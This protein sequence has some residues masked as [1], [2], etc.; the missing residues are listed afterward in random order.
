MNQLWIAFKNVQRNRRRSLVT[1][2]IAAAGTAAVMIGGGFALYT[3]DALR[4]Q[5]ARDSG[6]VIVAAHGFFDHDEE[7]PMQYGLENYPE[8]RRRLLLDARVRAVLPKVQLSGLISNGDKS[9]VMIG[10]GVDPAGEFHVRGPFLKVLEGD[11]LASRP[12]AGGTPEVLLGGDL[13]R[14]LGAHPGSGLTLMAT[15][16]EGALNAVDVAVKGVVSVGVPDVD[17]RLV[18]T[19]VSTAQSLL[20][21]DRISSLAVHLESMD[22]TDAVAADLARGAG[23]LSVQTWHDQAFFYDAVRALYNRIFGMLGAIIVLIVAFAVFNTI[24]MAVVERTREIGTLRAL[25]AMPGQI[26]LDFALEGLVIGAA[27]AALGAMLSLLASL[28]F[29]L[30]GLQMPPPPG[31]SVGYPL[32]I[33]LD[34][35]LFAGT[36]LLVVALS[37]LAAWFAS[38]KAASRPIVEALTHV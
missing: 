30:L 18:L 9:A 33:N 25:G 10:T 17:K 14:A 27:G 22:L 20:L 5:A 4:E 37:A 11:V 28:A 1:L 34:G 23:R 3:Y 2:A 38:R 7:K 21:T 13:A 15:T 12:Q 6:H 32:H 16:T 35:A 31:R 26:V 19:A 8:L 24:A 36:V 29:D